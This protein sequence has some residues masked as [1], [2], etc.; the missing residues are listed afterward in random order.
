MIGDAVNRATDRVGD[1]VTNILLSYVLKVVFA[2]IAFVLLLGVVACGCIA[3]FWWLEPTYGP[4]TSI[5]IVAGSLAVGVLIFGAAA[6]LAGRKVTLADTVQPVKV[7]KEESH[8]AVETVGPYKFVAAALGAGAL[9]GGLLG[10]GGGR[11]SAGRA[12]ASTLSSIIDLVPTAISA[13]TLLNST[14]AAR[15]SEEAI[16]SSEKAAQA[17]ASP[18]SAAGQPHTAQ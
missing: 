17:A 1:R 18:Q 2:A 12:T 6:M 3:A 16:R 4:M 9:A 13:L 14:N 5:A 8:E 10:G 15:A 11:Q 7:V